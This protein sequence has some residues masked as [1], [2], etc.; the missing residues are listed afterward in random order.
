MRFGV[1]GSTEVAGVPVRGA[2]LS[3]LLVLLALEAGR[4]VSVERLINDI[5]GPSGTV[6]ALQSQVSRL[7]GLVGVPLELGPGGYRLVVEPLQIDAHL[8]ARLVADARRAPAAG[9]RSRLL[10]EALGLWRGPALADVLGL[11]FAEGEAARLEELRLGALEDRVEAD[12]I[13][14]TAPAGEL[15]AELGELVMRHPLRERLRGQH[16]RAL[17]GAGR[18]AEALEAF[19]GARRTLAEELGVDPSPE[20]AELHLRLLSSA[21][22]VSTSGAPVSGASATEMPVS[23]TPASGSAASGAPISA[24][25]MSDAASSGGPTSEV[26]ASG[27]Q[28]FGGP[29][30]PASAGAVLRPR[31]PR[32]QPTS[33]VGREEEVRLIRE[34]L[35]EGRLLTLAG[36]GGAGKTRLAVEAAGHLGEV[37]FVELAPLG[38]DSDVALAVLTALGLPQAQTEPPGP[39][40]RP[41]VPNEPP[42]PQAHP[43]PP[44]PRLFPQDRAP[45]D[46]LVAAL[47]GHS[48][49]LVLDNCEHVVETAALLADRILAECPR[50]RLLATSREPFNIPGEQVLP[51]PPLPRPLL[52]LSLAEAR[53]HPAVRLL[54]DRAS[55][56]RHGF[57]VTEANLDAVLRI[58]RALDGLPLAIELAAARLRALTPEFV[59]AR[60]DD[61]FRLLTG[62]SRTASQRHRTL[63]D[64]VAW[65]WDLL[66][67]A[68]RELA[69]RLSVFASGATASAAERVCGGDLNLLTALADKSI[70]QADDGRF[71]MLE[72]VRAFCAERLAESGEQE[73]V[74]LAHAEWFAAMASAAEPQLRGPGQ[75]RCLAE[76]GA[77]HDNLRT[78]LRFAIDT[79]RIELALRLVADLWMYWWLRGIRHEGAAASVEV[80]DLVGPEPPPSLVE[81]YI[82]C[83]LQLAAGGRPV[84]QDLRDLLAHAEHLANGLVGPPRNPLV[85]MVRP[86][87]SIAEGDYTTLLPALLAATTDSD[88]WTR[89][90]A[91]LLVGY[92]HLGAGEVDAGERELRQA[93]DT[94][95]VAGDRWGVGQAMLQLSELSGWRGDHAAAIAMAE[96]A[97]EVIAPFGAAE[98]TALV[99]SR[100]GAELARAGDLMAARVELERAA[101]LV[102]RLPGSEAAAIATYGLAELARL[103]GDATRAAALYATA[104]EDCS[105]HWLGASETRGRILIGMGRLNGSGATLREAHD[106]L[107]KVLDL[108][109]ASG[110]V[111]AMAELTLREGAA[112]RA[113]YLL[114]AAESLRGVALPDGPDVART[115]GDARRALGAEAFDRSYRRG[116][117]TPRDQI[118]ES[119][120]Y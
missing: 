75:L 82:V 71:R 76:L 107:V 8:F 61:R 53:E 94:F 64:V 89:A 117:E 40:P 119:L 111:E 45:A 109:G 87:P 102:E 63:R 32:R 16:M 96:E 106:L 15:V 14:G 12:L 54:A 116:R 62:G 80:L 108:P 67:P 110:A 84:H 34:L 90:F 50:V 120:P 46:A 56:V 99:L 51:V 69:G 48:F 6:N 74:R 33:F 73:R 105:G 79:R 39:L 95:R 100:R 36:P 103:T 60:L 24:A 72:T 25:L 47:A 9:E 88:P 97:L 85:A 7:R 29:V 77:E 26:Q 113:A 104:L 22:D 10:R 28:A 27:S 65:S 31:G 55:A 70:L 98:D 91:R 20:L 49:T 13:D 66:D 118:A 115:A 42:G 59:A 86:Y 92:L 1:L 57:A 44:S 17:A 21:P 2:R 81:E 23:A 43:E 78:A 30:E 101:A 3:G 18:R 5:Y 38:P 58:C 112:A 114:G 83:A 93:L 68:E 4:V 37:C 11:P 19:E 52:D 41:Q 35:A